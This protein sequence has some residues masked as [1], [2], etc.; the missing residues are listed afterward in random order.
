MPCQLWLFRNYPK[1]KRLGA[2]DYSADYMPG[3]ISGRRLH[4]WFDGH[5]LCSHSAWSDVAE[6]VP[7]AAV[8]KLSAEGT[9]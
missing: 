4:G 7:G 8:G 1:W 5:K 2:V 6:L 9:W 3:R